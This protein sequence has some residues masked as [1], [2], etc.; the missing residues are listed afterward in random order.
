MICEHSESFV[1]PLNV[2][3]CTEE[4][5]SMRSIPNGIRQRYDAKFKLMVINCAKKNNC[6]IARQF[7]S[8]EVNV[9]MCKE[10]QQKLITVNSTRKSF[11]D[12]KQGHFQQSEQ[13]IVNF[14]CL[15]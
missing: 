1:I 3:P 2:R 13:E 4:A 15:K 12:P 6:N 11:N 5:T 7:S 14:V 8:V 10:Q 9:R